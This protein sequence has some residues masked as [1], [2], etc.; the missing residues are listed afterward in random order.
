M[1]SRRSLKLL[2]V[3]KGTLTISRSFTWALTAYILRN[4][5]KSVSSIH[6][7]NL[8]ENEVRKQEHALGLP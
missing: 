4:V 1:A 3:F 5:P 6:G 2:V 7:R 8:S